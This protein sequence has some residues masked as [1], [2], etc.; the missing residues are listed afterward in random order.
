[1][2]SI[3]NINNKLNMKSQNKNIEMQITKIKNNLKFKGQK[4]ILVKFKLF[5]VDVYL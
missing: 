2:D 3:I 5:L 4:R 1:M